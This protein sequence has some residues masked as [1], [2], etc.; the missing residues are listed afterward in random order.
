MR[1]TILVLASVALAMVVLGGVAWAATIHCNPNIDS[2]CTGTKKADTIYGN[3]KYNLIY[4]KPGGDT[5]YGRGSGDSLFVGP[6]PDKLYGQ[7]GPDFLLGS[8]GSDKLYGGDGDDEL[9]GSQYVGGNDY[10]DD[11]LHGGRGNDSLQSTHDRPNNNYIQRGVDKY[12]G[13]SGN[14]IIDVS[15]N[16][17]AGDSAKDVVGCGPG[18]DE[19]TFDQGVDVV[20][21]TC[22]I[23][24]PF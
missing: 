1:K 4:G 16:A 14:D 2:A 10:S 8:Q 7:R 11:Y 5:V 9:W 13:D 23:K 22:E 18:T 6:G 3:Y 12:Y 19:V 15:H 20:N 24:N 21:D 17:K